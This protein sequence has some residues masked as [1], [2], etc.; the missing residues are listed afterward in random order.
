MNAIQAERFRILDAVPPVLAK[1]GS[2][3]RRSR[4]HIYQLGG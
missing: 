4:K 2:W 3:N 1:L